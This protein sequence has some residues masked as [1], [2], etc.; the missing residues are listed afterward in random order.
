[1]IKRSILFRPGEHFFRANIALWL[2]IR[3]TFHVADNIRNR[4]AGE[5]RIGILEA[6]MSVFSTKFAIPIFG[7]RP[8]KMQPKTVNQFFTLFPASSI[9]LKMEKKTPSFALKRASSAF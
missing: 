1:M 7:L 5:F 4:L 2:L 3:R 8:L 9:V 6:V